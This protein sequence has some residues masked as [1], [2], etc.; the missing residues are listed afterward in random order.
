MKLFWYGLLG[1]VLFILATTYTIW[2]VSKRR[3]RAIRPN[4]IPPASRDPGMR[5]DN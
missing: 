1:A 3:G 4:Y 2:K 5:R